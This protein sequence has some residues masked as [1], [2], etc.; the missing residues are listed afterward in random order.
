[1]QYSV[2]LTGISAPTVYFCTNQSPDIDPPTLQTGQVTSL[3]TDEATAENFMRV[4]IPGMLLS[5]AGGPAQL[6]LCGIYSQH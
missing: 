1:M 6:R 3:A 5:V 4:G 2:T